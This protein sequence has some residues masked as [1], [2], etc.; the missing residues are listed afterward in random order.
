[1]SFEPCWVQVE[2]ERVNTHAA[3]AP[4]C[5][6]PPI[7]AV[8]P[9]EDSATLKPKLAVAGLAAARELW[10]LLG[11]GRARAREHPRR[12]DTAVVVGTA[13]QRGVAVARQR[14]AV[15]ESACADLAAAC[16]LCAL[17]GPGRARAREHPRRADAAVVA[18]AADQRRV[19]VGRQR[20]ADAEVALA[21]LSGAGELTACWMNGSI[22]SG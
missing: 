15:A 22:R 14:H 4:C 18:V 20:D 7:S 17:L 1:M 19:A 3:P 8:L 13:D 9:S 16:E 21:G 6:G 11:P 2:P 12:T 5:R 10:A